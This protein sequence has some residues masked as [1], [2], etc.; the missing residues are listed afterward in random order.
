MRGNSEQTVDTFAIK[1][2]EA[3][4]VYYFDFGLDN[5]VAAAKRETKWRENMYI[6]DTKDK[7]LTPEEIYLFLRNKYQIPE[8]MDFTEARKILSIWQDVQLNSWVA[9]EPVDIAYNVSIQTVAQ[10]QTHAAELNGMSIAE[11]TVRIYPRGTVAAHVIG[12]EGRI[13][14]DILDK[15][16]APPDEDVASRIG[17]RMGDDILKI[18]DTP[19]GIGTGALTDFGF[20]AG[21]TIDVKTL[22]DLGYGVDD[23]I[24]VE[25]IEKSM[26]AYLT[27]NT[28]DRQGKEKVEVDNMAVVQNVLSATEPTQGDNVMLTLD[29]GLQLVAEQALA[30]EIPQIHAAQVARFIENPE[31]DR[32]DDKIGDYTGLDLEDLDLACSGAVVVLDVNTGNVLAMANYPSYDL[33]TFTGGISEEDYDALK[34]MD[35]SPLFNKAIQSLAR[36]PAPFSRW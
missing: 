21:Q 20:T 30:D 36:C 15:Y 33:N 5:K 4:G 12:Y 34:D 31:T 22:L 28:T 10:I 13:T 32:T 8:E 19:S 6:P 1:Y 11:S 29:I 2:N 18:Y 26:E 25:G 3:A 35:G 9:Y 17:T 27:G 24:G 14:S 23:L 16:S 7:T